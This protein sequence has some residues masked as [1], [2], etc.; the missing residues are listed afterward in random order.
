MVVFECFASCTR[1]T[2]GKHGHFV[3]WPIPLPL[4][5]CFF[6]YVMSIS[7]H[8]RK[9]VHEELCHSLSELLQPSSMD[10]VI[11]NKIL[12]HSQ[13]FFAFIA[14]SM[15][16]HLLTTARIKVRR[17]KVCLPLIHTCMLVNAHFSYTFSFSNHQLLWQEM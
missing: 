13:F 1:I 2:E 17:S 3:N 16:L 11:T 9:T 10:Q 6:Q 15:A 7:C 12:R 5:I 14:R 4:T 8:G